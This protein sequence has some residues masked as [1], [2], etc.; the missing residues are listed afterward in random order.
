MTMSTNHKSSYIWSLFK[1]DEKDDTFAVC[2][3]CHTRIKRGKTSKSYSTTP[4]IK[5]AS[6][7]H[8]D[9]FKAEKDV[10][11]QEKQCCPPIPPPP[12]VRKL[13]AM[14]QGSEE[15]RK[16]QQKLPLALEKVNMWGPNDPRAKAVN[17]KV[18]QMIVTDNQPFTIVEDTGFVNLIAHLQPKYC[19]PSKRYFSE[20]MLPRLYEESRQTA[21]TM[22]E[23]A[24]SLAF[25]SD[26]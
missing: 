26:I 13:T 3:I 5:H 16:I 9:E 2:K 22:I 1:V 6:A 20:T 11:E 19:M 8:S 18:I 24:E 10:A 7:K 21:V 17:R 15:A 4:L 12:K 14:A 25:T 23:K